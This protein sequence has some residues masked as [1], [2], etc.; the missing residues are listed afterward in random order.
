VKGRGMR[1]GTTLTPEITEKLGL[2][3]S[4]YIGGNHGEAIKVLSEITEIAPQLSYVYSMLALIYEES[5]YSTYA[6]QLYALAAA[7][8]SRDLDSWQKVAYCGIEQRE[9]EQA[10][11]ALYRCC[12]LSLTKFQKAQKTKALKA[13]AGEVDDDEDEEDNY[14]TDAKNGNQVDSTSGAFQALRART[15]FK[16]NDSDFQQY[17]KLRLMLL[18]K[19]GKFTSFR[20]ALK[21]Y[22]QS[23]PNDIRVFC[24]LGQCF[25][26]E[27]YD[28][29]AVEY[30]QKFLEHYLLTLIQQNYALQSMQ[31]NSSSSASFLAGRSM[32]PAATRTALEKLSENIFDVFFATRQLGVLLLEG[33]NESSEVVELIE[34]LF[35]I[36]HQMKNADPMI[37]GISEIEFPMDLLLMLGLNK[38]RS[39]RIDVEVD[40]ALKILQPALTS[41]M[42]Y[43][44]NFFTI[45]NHNDT[46]DVDGEEDLNPLM[47]QRVLEDQLFVLYELLVIGE[48]LAEHGIKTRGR[49]MITF[50][51]DI[52]QQ[53]IN[54]NM[55]YDSFIQILSGA[56]VSSASALG[57]ASTAASAANM[58]QQVSFRIMKKFL[59]QLLSSSLINAVPTTPAMDSIAG[60]LRNASDNVNSDGQIMFQYSKCVLSRYPPCDDRF[61]DLLQKLKFFDELVRYFF[62]NL[63]RKASNN[64]NGTDGEED[65]T[66]SRNGHKHQDVDTDKFDED[67][68]DE[69]VTVDELDAQ[70]SLLKMKNEASIPVLDDD[71]DYDD[72]DEIAHDELDEVLQHALTPSDKSNEAADDVAIVNFASED[73]ALSQELLQ[74]EQEL[75]E[76]VKKTVFSQLHGRPFASRM[77]VKEI[78]F[79]LHQYSLALLNKLKSQL[80]SLVT[81]GTNASAASHEYNQEIST[82]LT[83]VFAWFHCY[84]R[85]PTL[86]LK[87]RER[88]ALESI[89]LHIKTFFDK[90]VALSL[91]PVGCSAP[92]LSDP[93]NLDPSIMAIINA[94]DADEL[95]GKE[96]SGKR[97]LESYHWMRRK[98]QELYSVIVT[99]CEYFPIEE[100]ITKEQLTSFAE[101]ANEILRENL[102]DREADILEEMGKVVSAMKI[103]DIPGT[104]GTGG[105]AGISVLHYS[106]LSSITGP[107]VSKQASGKHAAPPDSDAIALMLNSTTESRGQV[108]SRRL[109]RLFYHQRRFI[110]SAEQINEECKTIA[111]TIT[112]LYN[113]LCK[114]V[115]EQRKV[116]A[117]GK[118][119]TRLGVGSNAIAQASNELQSAASLHQL[120]KEMIYQTNLFT[121]LLHQ[122]YHA[123]TIEQQ[124]SASVLNAIKSK[125]IENRLP[126]RNIFGEGQL[127]DVKTVIIELLL[128]HEWAIFKKHQEVVDH[129][130][131]AYILDPEQPLTSLCLA[132][133]LLMLANHQL[134]KNRH[135]VVNKAFAFFLHYQH[136]RRTIPAPQLETHEHFMILSE[137]AKRQEAFYNFGRAFHEI[138]LPHL[139]MDQY[140]QA[141]SMVDD[142]PDLLDV[143]SSETKLNV[144]RQAAFNLSLLYK[145]SKAP[146]LALEVIT[147]Y[148]MFE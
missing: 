48:S 73:N 57:D 141:L 144:T 139:A 3:E 34:N 88:I 97:I 120:E 13:K 49:K 107:Q 98:D 51:A 45:V 64:K 143:S 101:K 55:V 63:A 47:D 86:R 36:F 35:T 100:F 7:Y 67:A 108:Q 119:L 148:L 126:I 95:M 93:G 118:N 2:A 68:K 135:E 43:P 132:T 78:I 104:S 133:Y 80:K 33:F 128:G 82:F 74:Q 44:E 38:L 71:M 123:G 69:D 109:N 27:G 10:L 26:E 21:P 87:T 125:Y 138:D 146:E 52:V 81:T 145:K 105:V 96:T 84:K 56:G 11:T 110:L 142:Y 94:M 136:L 115:Y 134:S 92:A 106:T 137:P 37:I 89:S 114:V 76:K 59:T 4:H 22:L 61:Q 91:L 50:V 117:K 17:S 6:L 129:Y 53:L 16:H 28:R 18:I 15:K 65:D 12:K 121:Q 46:M 130:L 25:F 72:G 127:K 66:G 5:G 32:N 77:F 70:E 90:M 30:F 85:I 99:L 20:E 83:M 39:A 131:N 19:T 112:M 1:A 54:N 122:Q 29:F 8:H 113:D 147:K 24:D 140:E 124:D 116:A 41:I 75:Q 40:A 111:E 9:Y 14:E 62:S 42:S 31:L 60:I 23:F 103:N 102:M 58:S 79:T